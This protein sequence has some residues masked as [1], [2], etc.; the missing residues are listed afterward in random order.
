MMKSSFT[1]LVQTD[2]RMDRRPASKTNRRTNG[3]VDGWI[4]GCMDE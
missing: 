2:G 1:V 4:G 3:R